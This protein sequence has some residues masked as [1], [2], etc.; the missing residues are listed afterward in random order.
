M[1]LGFVMEGLPGGLQGL[2]PFQPDVWVFTAAPDLPRGSAHGPLPAKPWIWETQPPNSCHTA[3]C[4]IGLLLCSSEV[5]NYFGN[6]TVTR[7]HQP[8]MPSPLQQ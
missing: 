5:Q 7:C 6:E 2:S 3:P 4:R 1:C 8:E